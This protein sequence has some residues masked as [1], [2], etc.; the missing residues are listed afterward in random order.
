MTNPGKSNTVRDFMETTV[1][2][3]VPEEPEVGNRGV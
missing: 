2:F 1:D 3:Q